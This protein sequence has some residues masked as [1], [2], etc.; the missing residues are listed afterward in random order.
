MGEGV[1]WERGWERGWDGRGGEMGEGVG[2][3]LRW[4]R[5]WERV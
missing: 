4:E 5:G 2:E 3:G 1:R